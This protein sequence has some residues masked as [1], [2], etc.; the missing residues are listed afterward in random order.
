VLY[1]FQIYY[2]KGT[3]NPADAPSRLGVPAAASINT[4]ANIGTDIDGDLPMQRLLPALR[5]KIRQSIPEPARYRDTG[6]GVEEGD[7]TQSSEKA[8]DLVIPEDIE[9]AELLPVLASQWCTRLE[10]LEASKVGSHDDWP[11]V[12]RLIQR[13][14]ELDPT[15]R[16][17][18]ELKLYDSDQSQTHPTTGRLAWQRGQ[19][20]WSLAED[21]RLLCRS[22]RIYVP[23]Q[24]SLMQELIRLHHD[25]P[26]A[27]HWGVRKTL[28]LLQRHF[29]WD[30]ISN[31]VKKYI[32]TCPACQGKAVH[33]HKP[34][35]KLS[36]LP[37]P[38]YPFAEISL[39]WIVG[40]PESRRKNG[41]SANAILTVVDRLT[42]YALFIP[43]RNDTTA[44][45]FSELF[46]KHV[47]CRFGT[48]R[49]VVSDRDS[50]ITSGYWA[51]ICT[52]Q[53]IKRR[54]STAYHP[55]TDGQSEALNRIV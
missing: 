18:K 55:Q 25:C 22:H 49:G 23:R 36:P 26:S 41:Q 13:A 35:G 52:Y 42:K 24:Q 9:V 19:R 39:D 1:N 31:D 12:N 43:T 45:D 50:R 10:V 28:D 7:W 4:D 21:G 11:D 8:L 27:G 2:R 53:Q 44:A 15:C 5:A 34:Y 20:D 38:E 30:G 17:V 6:K 47:E 32:A 29:D 16:R 40:L 51:E 54:M 37:I 3:L 48:P 14:Q 33:R 46:F